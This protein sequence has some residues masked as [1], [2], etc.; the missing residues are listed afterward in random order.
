MSDQQG[1]LLESI[2]SDNFD[3][4]DLFDIPIAFANSDKI[5]IWSTSKFN[6]FIDD[7]VKNKD[8]TKLFNLPEISLDH[9]TQHIEDT[10]F[11]TLYVTNKVKKK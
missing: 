2:S 6:S 5:I 8:F 3:T 7:K 1:E 10:L 9:N 11:F 4:F